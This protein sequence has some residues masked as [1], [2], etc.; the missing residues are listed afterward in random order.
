MA[1]EVIGATVDGSQILVRDTSNGAMM[2]QNNDQGIDPEGFASGEVSAGGYP[3]WSPGDRGAYIVVP[4]G[5]GTTTA[6]G[7]TGGTTTGGTTGASTLGPDEHFGPYAQY[8]RARGMGAGQAY[9]NPAQRYTAGLYDPLRSL[10]ESQQAVYGPQ[11]VPTSGW[12]DFINQYT[13]GNQGIMGGF[14]NVLAN[15]LGLGNEGRAQSGLTF[16]RTFDPYGTG[17]SQYE[18]QNLDLL[19]NLLSG[20]LA[21]RLGP[22]G[23]G[24]LANRIPF[25][26][27][28]YEMNPGSMS[29]IDYLK[30]KYNL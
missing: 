29:F 1:Y 3:T 26:Q 21:N 22:L 6:G 20:G 25:M 10:W 18:G 9:M 5:G 15:L 17:T 30:S 13:G 24:Y 14:A 7:T 23:A 28:Q 4:P 8:L 16:Q 19:Q 2:W 27:T 12:Q 11:N